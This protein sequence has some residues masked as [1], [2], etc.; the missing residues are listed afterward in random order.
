MTKGRQRTF[1]LMWAVA[2]PLFLYFFIDRITGLSSEQTIALLAFTLLIVIVSLFPIR[3]KNTSL[4]PLH[5]IALAVFLQFGLL[6]EMA[7]TQLALLTA[8]LMLRLTKRD[9][10]RIPFNS[11]IF[12]IVSLS[13]AGVFY[14]LGGTTGSLERLT[15]SNEIIPTIGYALTFF[16]S[17]HVIIYFSMKYVA[18]REGITFWDE[19]LKWEAISAVMIIPVGLTLTVLYEQIGFI[20]ILLMG[21]PFISVSLILR[22]YHNTETTNS[23]LKEVSS[24]GYKVNESL[25][26][27]GIISLFYKHA[28]AIFPADRIYLYDEVDGELRAHPMC[29]V[30]DI[31]LEGD[32]I[33]RKVLMRG[34][35]YH[36]DY[37]KQ[38][39]HMESR[40]TLSGS[41]SVL[42]VPVI[43]NNSS[44]G[45]VTLT[46]IRK[47]AFEK[48]HAMILE[49]M[50]NYMAV[51]AQNARNYEEKKR[52]SE[53]CALT[54][55]YNFRFFENLLLE[56]YDQQPENAK[57]FAIILL[58]LDRFKKVND[59]YGHHSGNEVLCQVAEVL[60]SEV[61][62][63]GTVARYGGEEFVILIDDTDVQFAHSLA[64]T[65]RRA[66][67]QHEFVVENDLET[68]NEL[69]IQVTASIGV[70]GKTE[71]DESAMGVLRNADR[72]MYTGA[73]QKGRNRVA[74]FHSSEVTS[75]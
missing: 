27:N 15:W 49:F 72:A 33:S 66:L 45:V 18:R 58:D 26:V 1:W 28:R 46:S 57:Q 69:T 74:N 53:R 2:F 39:S 70:A 68:G 51:A 10:Y 23:L 43:R 75:I 9:L 41:Q 37:Y 31:P 44:V 5:G 22:Q 47:K 6:V 17:N 65:L 52:E 61:A 54:G 20:A 48:R 8:L 36:F 24:F 38:W 32:R 7:V 19:G 30:E 64:E 63:R 71:P 21:I 25:T 59:T 50:A 11:I 29:E 3:V 13:S 56:K 40:D 62:E 12:M 55:L 67:E 60:R 73:K 34:T 42:S 35:S 14:L 16:V 4:I